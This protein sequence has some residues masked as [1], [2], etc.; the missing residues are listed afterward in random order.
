MTDDP[1]Q[2]ECIKI[3]V[4]IAIKNS[5]IQD[6]G[7]QF[8]SIDIAQG[9]FNET[10]SCKLSA[11]GRC[12]EL[13][14]GKSVYCQVHIFSTDGSG[15]DEEELSLRAQGSGTLV[16][17][18]RKAL[19]SLASETTDSHA[20][21]FRLRVKPE[22][23]L[24]EPFLTIINPKDH[25]WNSGFNVIEYIDCRVNEARTL[26]KS[27]EAAF[28]AAGNG[29]ASTKLIA[30][31]AVVPVTSAITSSHTEWHKSRILEQEIWKNYVPQGLNEAMVVYHWK[32][33]FSCIKERRFVSFSA[34]VKMQTRKSGTSTIVIYLVLA[35]VLGTLAS[36]FGS[37]LFQEFFHDVS[38]L[39][40]RCIKY[41]HKFLQL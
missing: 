38:E 11:N 7:K 34:F 6:L 14:E 12:V 23:P 17:I 18:T 28:Q 3:Y 29:V 31:L 2:L 8:T 40:A 33:T 10:L 20:G 26:P 13:L 19:R 37:I 4:P 32:K 24:K 5:E 41:F 27:V 22:D 16:T 39:T 1:K 21:Y 36:V 15:I 25:S 30:F 35:F 9:I